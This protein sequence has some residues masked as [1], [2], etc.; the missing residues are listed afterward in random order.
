M[1]DDLT[2]D[3]GPDWKEVKFEIFDLVKKLGSSDPRKRGTAVEALEDFRLNS[4]EV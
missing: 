4:K 2:L 1:S 3:D